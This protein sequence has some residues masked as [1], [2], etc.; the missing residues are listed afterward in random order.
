MHIKEYLRYGLD[1]FIIST[2]NFI[3]TRT[4]HDVK[5]SLNFNVFMVTV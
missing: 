1:L 4:L 5:F 2:V 3:N